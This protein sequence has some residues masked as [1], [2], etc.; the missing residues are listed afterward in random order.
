MFQN[1]N[2]KYAVS[3]LWHLLLQ[4]KS[5]AAIIIDTMN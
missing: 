3:T 1:H 5:G 2:I 4:A